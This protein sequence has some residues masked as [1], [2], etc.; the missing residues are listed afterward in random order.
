MKQKLTRKRQTDN[1]TGSVMPATHERHRKK[2]FVALPFSP[3]SQQKLKGIFRYAN[4]RA[5]WSIEILPSIH[6]FSVDFFKRAA[7]DG[8]D[9]IIASSSEIP[10]TLHE[11]AKSGIPVALIGN[12]TIRRSENVA[13]I[14][15]DEDSVG[16]EAA[17]FL[18]RD[19]HWAAYGYVHSDYGGAWDNR[20]GKAFREVLARHSE[21]C[22]AFPAES[23]GDWSDEALVSWLRSLP[24]PSAV[25]AADDYCAYR[26]LNA[27]AAANKRV[28]LDVTLLGVG[29]TETICENS[30]P[31]LTSVE[32][33][34]ERHGYV[35]AMHLDRMMLSKRPQKVAH[36]CCGVRRIVVRES[37]PGANLHAGLLVQKAFSFIRENAVRGIGVRDVISHLNVSRTLA[38]LRFREIVGRTIQGTI[39]DVRLE[40][41]RT[42]LLTSDESIASACARCGWKSENHPKKLFRKKFGISMR[43]FRRSASPGN[44]VP[45]RGWEVP[46]A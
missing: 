14:S 8:I 20:R 5:S 12:A 9:G 10:D 23:T 28:P 2:V 13:Y 40:Q 29:N 38:D 18:L 26:V 15:T 43:E 6:L 3:V 34:Y 39:F 31:S 21:N 24:R 1:K 7:A 32:I 16:R 25:L 35:A 45:P 44:V 17:L 33:D 36:E 30:S 22:C 41:T 46:H 37:A 19:A 11:I 27:C 42:A 4:G